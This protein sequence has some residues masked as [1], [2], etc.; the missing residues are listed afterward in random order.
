MS[1]ETIKF[2][3]NLFAEYWD[4][5]PEVKILLDDVP[6]I[7]KQLDKGSNN[8]TFV[9]TCKFNEPH[10]LTI[11]RSGKDNKQVKVNYDGGLLDQY[12]ILQKIVIDGVDIQNIIQSRSV[13]EAHY[14]E[15]WASQQLAAGIQLEKAAIGVT[16][17]GHNGIWYLN[18][19]SPFYEYLMKWMGGGVFNDE[20]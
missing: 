8:L 6:Q 15:P 13:F 16:T 14:P 20:L 17:F 9:E 10:R 19:T 7:D 2:S 3:I 18:F 12:V 11:I 4:K 1:K 5:P